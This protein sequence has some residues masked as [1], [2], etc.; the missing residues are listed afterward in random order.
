MLLLAGCSTAVS[1]NSAA[2]LNLSKTGLVLVTWEPRDLASETG[3]YL[4]VRLE[5][6][7]GEAGR[8]DDRVIRNTR[9]VSLI[10]LPP[11]RYRAAEYWLVDDWAIHW[12]PLGPGKAAD[13]FEFEVRTA[14]VTYLGNFHTVIEAHAPGQTDHIAYR[15]ALCL[16]D[17]SGAAVAAFRQEYPALATAP[18]RDAAPQ[19][20][21]WNLHSPD[22]D[23]IVARNDRVPNRINWDHA[24]MRP[25][26]AVKAFSFFG[27]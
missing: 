17:L 24:N 14:E 21:A 8:M 23:D 12:G 9:P 16:Q 18:V 4:E 25:P 6:I 26:E 2:K 11:G 20:L 7:P 5:R 15:M 1:P 13:V 3:K 27:P 22:P 19:L 10:E